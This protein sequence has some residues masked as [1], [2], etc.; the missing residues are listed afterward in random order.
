[1]PVKTIKDIQYSSPDGVPLRL[2]IHLPS[3]ANEPLPVILV[4]PG[5][6]WSSCSKE[7][8]PGL[9]RAG[10]AAVCINYRV[11][12]IAIAPANIHDCKAAV[13]WVKSNAAEYGL[14]PVRVGV[15][16]VSAGGH[17]AMMMGCSHGVK[18]LEGKGEEHQT[19][20]GSEVQ[21]VC[22]VCGPTDLTRIAIPEIRRGFPDLYE[23]T[24]RYLGAPVLERLELARLVSPLTYASPNCPPMMLIHG[25]ADAI[26]PVEESLIF[27]EALRK[28]GARTSLRIVEGGPHSSLWEQTADDVIAF[29]TKNLR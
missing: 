14:N 7:C 25:D 20:R 19:S 9:A 4:I 18:E 27:H 29:F 26:V 8:E 12:S 15:Y 10:F 23:V 5:G 16:G 17:L 13:R 1:M 2:D 11:S 3:G 24:Q 28:A 6:G 21:A 22:A